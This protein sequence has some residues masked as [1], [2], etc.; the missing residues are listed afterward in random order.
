MADVELASLV[1]MAE[2]D[3]AAI[4]CNEQSPSASKEYV[5]SPVV[6][7]LQELDRDAGD[8]WRIPLPIELLAL[9]LKKLDDAELQYVALATWELR[10]AASIVHSSRHSK[11]RPIELDLVVPLTL[12]EAFERGVTFSAGTS[13]PVKVP[14][15]A[16]VESMY[17]NYVEYVVLCNA[18]KRAYREQTKFVPIEF[19]DS[20]LMWQA[21]GRTYDRAEEALTFFF[22]KEDD[23]DDIVDIVTAILCGA[24]SQGNAALTDR[25]S[26][27]YPYGV[28]IPAM[29]IAAAHGAQLDII[30]KMVDKRLLDV[31]MIHQVAVA[32]V[33]HHRRSTVKMCA[34]FELLDY[35][36]AIGDT[37]TPKSSL[38]YWLQE[39]FYPAFDVCPL[40][41]LIWVASRAPRHDRYGIARELTKCGRVDMLAWLVV[42]PYHKLF[43]DIVMNQGMLTVASKCGQLGVLKWLHGI[44]V[45]ADKLMAVDAFLDGHFDVADWVAANGTG[46]QVTLSWEF[47][48]KVADGDNTELLAWGLKHG[49]A[50]LPGLPGLAFDRGSLCVLDFMEENKWIDTGD[51]L[52][53]DH[54][55]CAVVGASTESLQWLHNRDWA[56]SALDPAAIATLVAAYKDSLT[57]DQVLRDEPCDVV[58]WMNGHGWISTIKAAALLTYARQARAA[59]MRRGFGTGFGLLGSFYYGTHRVAAEGNGDAVMQDADSAA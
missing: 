2:A 57:T 44:G 11:P 17:P 56:R 15:C 42:G 41:S 10:A 31:D 39:A 34:Q 12:E 32:A 38:Q 23:V 8:V 55:K 30:R 3:F 25:I 9:I 22:S 20:R 33:R 18:G 52:A 7:R 46:N 14:A 27:E 48:R 19:M 58:G 35:I 16:F 47:S 40:R 54:W 45:Y 6:L 26:C 51:F 59:R 28:D 37:W 24:A 1:T 13:L 43:Y 53:R 4:A 49:P 21:I 36:M 5:P 50:V 29:A